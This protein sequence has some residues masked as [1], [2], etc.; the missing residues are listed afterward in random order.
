MNE[1]CLVAALQMNSTP[2]VEA[3]L[4]QAA[5]LIA[6]A[7]AASAK[8]VMLPESF[9][10][11]GPD[12]RQ[13]SVAESLHD[14]DAP[15]QQVLASWARDFG[16]E[17]IAGGFWEKTMEGDR[18]HNACLHIDTAGNVTA[19]YRKIH[20]FDVNLADGTSLMESATVAPGEHIA[21]ADTACGRMGL[22]VCY[23][24]RFPEL[25]RKLVDQG[26]QVLAV[27]AAF[28]STTGKDHWEV[29]LRARAIESQ[30]FVVAAAQTGLHHGT[31]RSYGHAMIVD[32]WGT[33]RAACG[34]D[35]GF[36]VAT[37]DL[38]MGDRIR[39]QLP[40][41]AHRRLRG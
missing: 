23:D 7:A 41:L 28:T 31:R 3:N 5:S 36:A 2:D 17:I 26:A 1:T 6:Q 18:V 22:S 15:I 35:V 14:T 39:T 33:V 12:V 32:P 21:V 29:L 19:V 16:V 27:P 25:Y 8:L 40:S 34:E 13:A 24:L 9:A 30:C 37:V 38:T 20:L 4:A 10:Y 11:L